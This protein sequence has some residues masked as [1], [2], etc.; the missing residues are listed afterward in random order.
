MFCRTQSSLSVGV[1][2]LAIGLLAAPLSA[3]NRTPAALEG[4]IGLHNTSGGTIDFRTGLLIDVLASGSVRRVFPRQFVVGGGASVVL[5]GFGDRC[6]LTPNGGC[7]GKG[8]F[9]VV[10]ALVGI[11]QALGSASAR[12]L[13]G[14]AIYDGAGA[15][16]AGLQARV[17]FLS[18][19]K[20][21]LG[22]MVRTTV[23]PSHNDQALVALA[24]GFSLAFR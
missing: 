17:D 1:V 15:R 12:F 2:T 14:P 13:I 19:T 22:A 18:L 23:L 7:A 9:T 11:E 21:A 5:G 24:T 3:Q 8:N 6:L 10:N 4:T 20:V 16:S